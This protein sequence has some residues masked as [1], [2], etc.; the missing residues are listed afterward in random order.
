[1][2]KVKQKVSGRFRTLIG[3]QLFAQIRGYILTARKNAV[4]MFGALREAFLGKPF[5]LSCTSE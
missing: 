4:N 1:M 3:A 5:I 2:V